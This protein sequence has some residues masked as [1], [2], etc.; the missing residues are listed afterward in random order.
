[1]GWGGGVLVLSG[2]WFEQLSLNSAVHPIDTTQPCSEDWVGGGTIPSPA[3]G[4]G[5]DCAAPPVLT[6][7][8]ARAHVL[9]YDYY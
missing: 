9:I 6:S 5:R 8:T 3:L 1:M 2:K 7:L 4:G